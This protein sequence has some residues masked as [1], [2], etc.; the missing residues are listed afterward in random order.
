MFES[1]K[2]SCACG[3]EA[4]SVPPAPFV[5]KIAENR[6]DGQK[7]FKGPAV[8]FRN[9][10]LIVAALSVLGPFSVDT[11]FP[12]FPALAKHFQVTEIQMQATLSM[13]LTA[14]AGM[15]LFHGAISDS[16]GRRRVI[17]TSLFVY[18]LTALACVFA[19]NFTWLLGLRIVQGLAA[20]AGM[21]V[22]RA[23]VRDLYD[24]AQ[25][26]KLMAQTAM[27]GGVGPVLAPIM[28]G[29][30]HVWFGWRGP[31]MFLTLLGIAIWCLC[32][33]A[34]PE[35]LPV[36]LRQS[37]Q[38]GPLL[39]GYRDTILHRRFFLTSMC[40]SLG[41]GGFL[42]Y[43][44]TADDV[45]R[46]ILGL[47]PTQFWCMFMPI[48]AGL[49]IG[50]AVSTRLAGRVKTKR[51]IYGGFAFMVF[52]AF[53][54]FLVNFCFEHPPV[55]LAVMPISFYTFGCSLVAPILTVESLDIFPKRRGMASSLQGFLQIII[56]ALISGVVAAL[57]YKSGLKHSI[58]MIVL[59]GLSALAF[60]GSKPSNIEYEKSPKSQPVFPLKETLDGE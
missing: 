28:G 38:P 18:I 27:V 45:V 44:A 55:P 22:S 54:N 40:L 15:N 57:V 9:I 50:S 26:Q 56:F 10:I 1:L 59:L 48:V 7:G 52:G 16:F 5:A 36:R 33:V 25:A 41:A 4:V 29:W 13:Y 34:L 42:I 39:R 12:S 58:G 49:I 8:K 32:Y 6:P 2:E 30:L 60:V 46:N 23:V 24:G 14:L 17:L 21:I 19:P 20:G 47:G 35:S 31:F 11:Y 51:Q 43:I 53:V 3:G 37:F